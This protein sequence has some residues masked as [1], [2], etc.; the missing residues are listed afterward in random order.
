MPARLSL[1]DTFLEGFFEEK[2]PGRD[3]DFTVV[4]DS[5]SY[6]D[7]PNH[8]EGMPAFREAQALYNAFFQRLENTANFDVAGELAILQAELQ[9]L[10]DGR[11]LS[12]HG[13]RWRNHSVR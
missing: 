4:A 10:F 5:L 12:T 13:V 9:L 7:N 11:A 1:Q 8:E 2:F 3:I 6:P